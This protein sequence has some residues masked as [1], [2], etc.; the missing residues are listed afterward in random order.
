MQHEP[1]IVLVGLASAVA[2]SRQTGRGG[3]LGA[4]NRCG[5]INMC[6]SRL[7]AEYG[8]GDVYICLMCQCCSVAV[9]P[10]FSMCV[11]CTPI[12]EGIGAIDLLYVT[13]DVAFCTFYHESVSRV[14]GVISGV[15]V[16]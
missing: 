11:P 10:R 6:A 8:V 2:A 16:W 14:L 1:R 9:L 13:I 3:G 12:N 7:P 4:M 15:S 5:A